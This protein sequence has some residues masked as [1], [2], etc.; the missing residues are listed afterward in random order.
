[1]KRILIIVGI[2]L[3]AVGIVVAGVLLHGGSTAPSTPTRSLPG[4]VLPLTGTGSNSTSKNAGNAADGGTAPGQSSASLT[5]VSQAAVLDYA[6]N[7]QMGLLMVDPSGAV[8]LA[9]SSETIVSQANFGKILGAWFAPDGK[10]LLVES[11][12]PA[13]SRWSLLNIAKKTWK[14]IVA[15]TS[16]MEWSPAGDELAYFAR[17]TNGSMLTVFDPQSN[18]TK[19]L[20]SLSAPDLTLRWENASHMLIMDRPS[21][22]VAG[23]IWSFSTT[24]GTLAPFATNVAGALVQWGAAQNSGLLFTAGPT[25]GTLAVVDSQGNI[26]VNTSFLTLPSKCAFGQGST[27][28]GTVDL[29]DYFFCAVPQN[30]SLFQSHQLPDDYLKKEFGTVDALYAVNLSSGTTVPI[31]PVGQTFSFDAGDVKVYGDTLYFVNQNDRR[32]YGASLAG[33]TTAGGSDY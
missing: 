29:S 8:I 22:L 7:P 1:M 20:L 13:S 23:T 2:F 24:A 6:Q 9:L 16:E 14:D 4:G 30:K 31:V 26:P 25:G 32:L 19:S 3:A 12:D 5:A 11:G 17:R 15:N 33:V 18:S 27:A 21:A 28:S 10:W